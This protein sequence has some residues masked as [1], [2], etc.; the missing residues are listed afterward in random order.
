M[1][2]LLQS[3][4]ILIALFLF[5]FQQV[6]ARVDIIHISVNDPKCFGSS[7]GYVVIDS[8]TTTAPSG[9]YTIRIN[10]TPVQ[11]F[12]V[13]DTIQLGDGN[14]TITVFDG[15]DGNTPAF[16]SFSIDEPFQLVTATELLAY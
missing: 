12:N 4:S 11:F 5:S 1:K 6:E 9:N 10:T 7:D 8:L 16:R 2:S 3:F 15:D 14:Y 13:G